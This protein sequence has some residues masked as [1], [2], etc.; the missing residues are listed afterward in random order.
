MVARSQLW[1]DQHHLELDIAAEATRR[2]CH[3]VA[4]AVIV[5]RGQSVNHQ[6]VSLL[7]MPMYDDGSVLAWAKQHRELAMRRP[8]AEDAGYASAGRSYVQTL[9]KLFYEAQLGLQNVY[10]LWRRESGVLVLMSNFKPEQIMID[11]DHHAR[12]GD[13][14]HAARF[15]ANLHLAEDALPGNGRFR[16]PE[17]EAQLRHGTYAS[18]VK[19]EVRR[20]PRLG[21]L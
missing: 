9:T 15:K 19:S 11:A 12:V 3:H 13:W 17:Q 7:V 18:S 21:V 16:A 4:E 6:N 5:V 2:R 8:S 10:E 14:G 20:P 1:L